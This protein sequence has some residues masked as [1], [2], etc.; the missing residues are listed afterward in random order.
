MHSQSPPPVPLA[1]GAENFER[2]CY[3]VLSERLSFRR[4]HLVTDRFELLS[5]VPQRGTVR[6]HSRVGSLE[7][8]VGET[9]EGVFWLGTY[10]AGNTRF[11]VAAATEELADALIEE[12]VGDVPTRSPNWVDVHLWRYSEGGAKRWSRTCRRRSKM[13]P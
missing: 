9:P 11:E 3:M 2:A 10:P 7:S 8:V 1:L 5:R 4:A 13:R 12:L 6:C